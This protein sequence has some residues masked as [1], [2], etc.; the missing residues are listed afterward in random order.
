MERRYTFNKYVNIIRQYVYN[1]ECDNKHTKRIKYD[2][3]TLSC[4]S[5]VYISLVILTKEIWITQAYYTVS[6]KFSSR[7]LFGGSRNVNCT[8]HNSLKTDINKHVFN[9]MCR[10]STLVQAISVKNISI[11]GNHSMK[12][13]FALPFLIN[14]MQQKWSSKSD[15]TLT[16][17]P[18]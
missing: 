10:K 2:P 15:A 17:K 14:R 18:H 16:E 12:H 6:L 8:T 4:H 7:L 11:R 1:N 13:A 3:S 9:V 5:Y